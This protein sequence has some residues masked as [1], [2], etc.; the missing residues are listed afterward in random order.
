MR[1]FIEVVS[2]YVGQRATLQVDPIT[3]L[4]AGFSSPI[5]APDGPGLSCP[6]C[7]TLTLS[8]RSGFEICPV[9]FWTDDGQDDPDADVVRDGPNAKLSLTTARQN[10]LACGAASAEFKDRVRAPL[11]FER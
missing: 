4:P 3:K 10:F 2:A 6:C 1:G 8:R 9:C 5:I 11:P 7:R